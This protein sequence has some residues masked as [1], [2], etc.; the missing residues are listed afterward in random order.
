MKVD[1][2]NHCVKFRQSLPWAIIHDLLAH[3]FMAMTGYSRI[4]IEFHNFSSHR[5]WKRGDVKSNVVR[6]D[7]WR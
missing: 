5:A 6:D 1:P 3:P 7:R 4:A 2:I